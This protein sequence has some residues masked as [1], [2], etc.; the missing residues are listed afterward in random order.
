MIEFDLSPDQNHEPY[1]HDNQD[2][3]SNLE[4][5]TPDFC[6]EVETIM[7]KSV[8]MTAELSNQLDDYLLK[9]KDIIF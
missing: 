1:R 6:H 9:H 3:M 5:S 2:G 8:L 4:L 7:P